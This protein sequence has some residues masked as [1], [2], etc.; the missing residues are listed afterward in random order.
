MRGCRHGHQ[1]VRRLR[2]SAMSTARCAFT[3]QRS[4]PVSAQ[5]TQAA[6]DCRYPFWSP[7]GKRLYFIS[8]ARDRESL[9]SISAAGAPQVVIEDVN[10]ATISPDAGTIAFL[11]DERPEV[12]GAAALWFWTASGGEERH[13]HSTTDASLRRRLPSLQ[14]EERSR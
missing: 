5:I 3:R 13:R 9:W 10:R 7:D 12:V 1:M 4:S 11:R 8:L 14:M 6:Y 2:T